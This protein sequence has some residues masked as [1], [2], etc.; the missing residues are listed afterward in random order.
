M[1]CRRSSARS[2]AGVA[3]APGQ[4]VECRAWSPRDRIDRSAVLAE[5]E[6]LGW[7][8]ARP[9]MCRLLRQILLGQIQHAAALHEP[10]AEGER[11]TA[12]TNGSGECDA[13]A[14]PLRDEYG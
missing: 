5:S 3:R 12:I 7:L 9:E 14:A 10:W 11:H 4:A 6:R 2:G 1:P 8:A 13:F